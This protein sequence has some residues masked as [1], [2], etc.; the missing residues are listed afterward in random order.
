MKRALLL[1]SVLVLSCIG[2][3][4]SAQ[5]T[6]L[7]SSYKSLWSQIDTLN[8]KSMPQSV[9]TLAEKI[10]QKAN[11][12]RNSKQKLKALLQIESANE[13]IDGERL[14]EMIR[15][16]EKELK[17]ATPVE[18]AFLHSYLADLYTQYIN[19]N[20]WKIYG[21]TS[22][23]EE[24]SLSLELW[25]AHRFEKEIQS[26]YQLSVRDYSLLESLKVTDYPELIEVTSR[27]TQ[28]RPTVLD[29]LGH[30]LIDYYQNNS[31]ERTDAGL[32]EEVTDSLLFAPYETF[33]SYDVNGKP[34]S[35]AVKSCLNVYRVLGS[36]LLRANNQPA[37]LKLELERFSYLH[38]Q[39]AGENGDRLYLS[40]L[41]QLRNKAGSLSVGGEIQLEEADYYLEKGQSYNSDRA[42][43][44]E[45]ADA[46]LKAIGLLEKIIGQY[47]GNRCAEEASNRLAELKNPM[48]SVQQE[49]AV[50]P[51]ENFPVRITYKGLKK[52]QLE[53][54]RV[55]D[56][57]VNE[58]LSFPAQKNEVQ[59]QG[60][61]SFS[62][63][64]ELPDDGDWNEHATII[65][66][67]G[68][69]VGHYYLMCST[70][71]QGDRK[72]PLSLGQFTVTRLNCLITGSGDQ[73]VIYVFDRVTGEPLSGVKVQGLTR[74]YDASLNR[75]V[76]VRGKQ[77]ETD[78]S[79]KASLAGLRQGL[80]FFELSNGSDSFFSNRT[81]LTKI[82]EREVT[83]RTFFFTD[84]SIYR[85][86][87]VIHYKGIVLGQNKN[88][89]ATPVLRKV[90]VFLQDPNGQNIDSLKTVSDD[91]GSF[92]GTFHVSES[93][94]NGNYILREGRSQ[95][96]VRVEAYRRPSF[97]IGINK[98]RQQFVL[99]RPVTITGNLKD[100]TGQPMRNVRVGYRVSRNG[101][102]SPVFVRRNTE[103]LVEKGDVRTDEKG[104]FQ[105]TIPLRADSVAIKDSS[106]YYRFNVEV[107]ATS[108]AGETQSASLSLN[109]GN[110][111]LTI[112][113]TISELLNVETIK[114]ERIGIILQNNSGVKV[115]GNVN[116]KCYRLNSSAF[117]LKSCNWEKTDRPLLSVEQWAKRLPAYAYEDETNPLR[118]EK[119][120]KKEF[121]QNESDSTLDLSFLQKAETGK[122]AVTFQSVDKWG[123]KVE[124]TCYFNLVNF[125]QK[126]SVLPDEFFVGVARNTSAPGKE[127]SVPISCSRISSGW[128]SIDKPGHSGNLQ[129][130]YNK[131]LLSSLEIPVT[132][133]C[134]GGIAI[135]LFLTSANR[136][137][138]KTIEVEVP[139]E[140]ELTIQSVDLKEEYRPG[141]KGSLNFLLKDHD[142]SPVGAEVTAVL[143]D[144]SLDQIYPHSWSFKPERNFEFAGFEYSP[145]SFIDGMVIGRNVNIKEVTREE[146][147]VLKEVTNL[148]MRLSL[149]TK[150]IMLRGLTEHKEDDLQY[151]V[152]TSLSK[153]ASTGNAVKPSI[154]LIRRN[155]A[156]TAFF[157]SDLKT[158]ENGKIHF[159][160]TL[161]ES[162]TRWKLMLLAHTR[163]VKHGLYSKE[164]VTK[165]NLMIQSFFP[166][167]AR[168]GDTLVFS[169][170]LQNASAS[171][172]NGTASFLVSD[173]VAG[174]PLR[175]ET[176]DQNFDLASG[177]E[178]IVS[179]KVIVPK[180]MPL[181]RCKVKA[182][183][184]EE[185][186]GEE[187][188][189]PVYSN[190]QSLITTQP[191][192]F[193]PKSTLNLRD[194]NKELEIS[195]GKIKKVVLELTSNPGWYA[196]EAMRHGGKENKN[197]S[198]SVFS[199]LFIRALT[200]K[201]LD[202]N[203]SIRNFVQ[204][205]Y[206][207]KKAA[208]Q[209]PLEKNP[210]LKQFV[211]N[212]TPWVE[213]AKSDQFNYFD[214]DSLP[215]Q[216]ADRLYQL[217]KMQRA[218]GGWSWFDG[219]R[220]SNQYVSA[221]ILSG[222]AR[223][224]KLNVITLRTN[225]EANQMIRRGVNYLWKELKQDF[226][227][228]Q[229]REENHLS[230]LSVLTLYTYSYFR[231]LKV[232]ASFRPAYEYY[233]NQAV[234]FWTK[235]QSGEQ[236]M[237]AMALNRLGKEKVA[238]N[239]MISL[240][241]HAV[242]KK[243]QMYWPNTSGWFYQSVDFHAMMV[244]AFNEVN[245]DQ[246]A[247]RKICY[248]LLQQKRTHAWANGKETASALYALLSTGKMDSNDG[249]LQVTIDGKSVPLDAFE[250]NLG[251]LKME[252]TSADLKSVTITNPNA[253][254][255]WG[256]IYVMQQVPLTQ[257][258]EHGSE[259]RIRKE[260]FKVDQQSGG[261][262]M[263]AIK[264]G[265]VL[266]SGD[267]VRIRMIV[268]SDRD[269]EYVSLL[270]PRGAGFEPGSQLSGYQWKDELSYYQTQTDMDSRFFFTWFS[271]GIHVLEYDVLVAHTGTFATGPAQIQ[272][273]YAPEFTAYSGGGI[274]RTN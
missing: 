58:E 141:E 273:Q 69:P 199:E 265:T 5:E 256:G 155:F 168:E 114:D 225:P 136:A 143:Y 52:I 228:I 111:A 90:N 32:Y 209:S 4:L 96:S 121:I 164:L 120:L 178:Q 79:G 56:G 135:H 162:L 95:S 68:L 202:D 29:V 198:E 235:E 57:F 182:V 267:H 242:E 210:E 100:M 239:I 36:H 224:E 271:K 134:R 19:R 81:F 10:Y 59:K 174:I 73:K 196:V 105:L 28:F 153:Q 151:V 113:A 246:V 82:R 71:N 137:I 229:K 37:F 75:N 40:A 7:N 215:R 38:S 227:N 66:V 18:Q 89:Q 110:R 97:E 142:G 118:W 77:L 262:T 27:T 130:I 88:G 146:M 244:E 20:R 129:R 25:D 65:D 128:Y 43:N 258:A 109:A 106:V 62:R 171:R 93:R 138:S 45:Y 179:W 169:S 167:I 185:Q 159:D 222:L 207:N 78:R 98:P 186:D 212:Q 9:L 49:D 26:H 61:L 35:D 148:G 231:D 180:G 112:E 31:Q 214:P 101:N 223:L 233:L 160:F 122:Y 99:N 30:R 211:L 205:G 255:A 139:Y 261:E 51:N 248:W 254:I 47:A 117:G 41:D 260:F 149:N 274:L 92:S 157:Y 259:I 192:S 203:V 166:R 200:Q 208:E 60:K 183:A 22:V 46:N 55:S 238:Q 195:G 268:E 206:E 221:Y 193:D 80:T 240:R 54:F 108:I 6:T 194:L 266:T 184:G 217:E 91:Y 172:L 2:F 213:D 176:K 218:D 158:D 107:E 140:N 156:E 50:L 270:D 74:T 16:F 63:G 216:V 234:R 188:L 251:Y 15:R 147:P 86:G 17:S 249:S 197:C 3:Q 264:G 190:Q 152:T 53:V 70:G 11:A 67:R 269:L 1:I 144:A 126:K 116:V 23:D 154:D 104:N 127:I 220:S 145:V 42:E 94:L 83:E 165:K 177:T 175:M 272:C 87:Q 72:D 76:I 8:K 119:I 103:L 21:R 187:Q 13:E 263:T 247:V 170:R 241:E 163:D 123:K 14:P 12:E 245:G 219:E 132:D 243:G 204:K 181:I 150:G 226:E 232:E 173:G 125:T 124:R 34:W 131:G 44:K 115:P 133:D 24:D 161:P 230:M 201:V 48:L 84:R 191:L 253:G 64:I 33:K 257:K 252:L 237:L 236:V 39:Y 250:G 102:R 85:P 189:I